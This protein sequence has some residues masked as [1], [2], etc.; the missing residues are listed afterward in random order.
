MGW[1]Q[2]RILEWVATSFSRGSSQPTNWTWVSCPGRWTLYHTNRKKRKKNP[3]GTLIRNLQEL[4]I[5]KIQ[6]WRRMSRYSVLLLLTFSGWDL[7]RVHLPVSFEPIE[8]GR[9]H[10]RRK[11]KLWVFFFF[12]LPRRAACRILFPWADVG[13]M[14]PDCQG[15][16]R[17]GLFSD[18]RP[19]KC[20][21]MLSSTPLQTGCGWGCLIGSQGDAFQTC[22]AV[23]LKRLI[24]GRRICTQP[25]ATILHCSV[26]CRASAR[27]LPS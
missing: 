6:E 27:G 1:R 24:A 5:L 15:N 8:W 9:V 13:S 25:V 19:E 21:L 10:F 14:P 3:T 12:F 16:P 11:G 20:E 23:L 7:T 17:K 26:A 18:L 2:A 22:T 4:L